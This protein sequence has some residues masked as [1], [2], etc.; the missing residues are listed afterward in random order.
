MENPNCERCGSDRTDLIE[1][2]HGIAWYE[3]SE[4]GYETS[5]IYDLEGNKL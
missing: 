3:C 2:D 5:V 1:V 4:C